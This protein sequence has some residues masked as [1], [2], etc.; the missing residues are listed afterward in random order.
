MR[1]C[2][3]VRLRPSNAAAPSAALMH[4]A[5]PSHMFTDGG[6]PE[7]AGPLAPELH[8]G[9]VSAVRPFGVNVPGL[10][11]PSGVTKHWPTRED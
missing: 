1:E 2:R 8:P 4:V 7:A 3:V 9:R 11:G 5:V 10:A 6:N